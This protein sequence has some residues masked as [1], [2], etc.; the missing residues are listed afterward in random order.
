MTY[1]QILLAVYLFFLISNLYFKTKVYSNRKSALLFSVCYFILGFIWDYYAVKQG[2]W[3]FNDKF[4]VGPKYLYIP[5]DEYLF[6]VII[7]YCAISFY[8]TI[9]K[10]VK[11]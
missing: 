9:S 7:P 11:P 6:F 8:K 3:S 2:H 10:F 4:L 1:L 5:L